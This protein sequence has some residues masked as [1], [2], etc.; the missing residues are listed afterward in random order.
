LQLQDR[1]EFRCGDLLSPF[2]SEEFVGK[3]DV[4][5]CNPPYITSANLAHLPSETRDHEPRLAFDGGAFGL[6]VIS[7]VVAESPHWLRPSSPLCFEVG[8]ANGKFFAGRVGRNDRY[9]SVEPIANDEG[10]VRVIVAT[11][12]A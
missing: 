5:T 4:L 9:A 11:S 1:V 12:R 3:I 10:V 2:D 6:D 7:R 8:A